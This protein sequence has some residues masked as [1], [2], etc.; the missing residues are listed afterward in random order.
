MIC[1]NG[2]YRDHQT[3]LANDGSWPAASGPAAMRRWVSQTDPE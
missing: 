2:R 3:E 1:S